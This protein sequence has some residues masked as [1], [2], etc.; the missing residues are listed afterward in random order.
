MNVHQLSVSC[1]DCR[2]IGRIAAGIT[3]AT[4]NIIS[5]SMPTVP[6]GD[7]LAVKEEL[8][9]ESAVVTLRKL[10]GRDKATKVRCCANRYSRSP[11]TLSTQTPVDTSVSFCSKRVIDGST[12]AV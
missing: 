6:I 8:S 11:A 12:P 10:D 4:K 3:M 7:A 9:L 5:N 1:Q 2:D